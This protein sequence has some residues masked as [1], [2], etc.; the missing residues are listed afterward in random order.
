MQFTDDILAVVKGHQIIHIN[1][2][3][4]KELNTK[5]NQHLDVLNQV[6]L[7]SGQKRGIGNTP[8]L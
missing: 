3:S 6:H 1:C 4:S 2:Q 5:N 8:T 7:N